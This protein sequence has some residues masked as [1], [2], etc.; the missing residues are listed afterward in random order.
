MIRGLIQRPLCALLRL[1]FRRL[2]VAGRE[3]VPP[4]GPLIFILNHPNA[5]IDPL[6]LLCCTGRPVSFLAKQPLFGMPLI[7]PVV[8]AMESIPVYRRMD[9][10][11]T[12][13]N[14]ATFAAAR[15]LLSRGGSLALFPEGT[16]HSDPRLKPFRTGA[17]RIALGA[18]VA[19]LRIVPAG[20]FYTEKSRFRSQALLCFGGPV[21]V[22]D[23]AA[24]I[25]SEPL[26]EAVRDLTARLEQALGNL[27]LQADEHAALHLAEAAERIFL[28]A[29]DSSRELA[30]RLEIRRRL[31]DGYSR[32]KRS[33][34]DRLTQIVEKVEQYQADLDAAALTPEL[35]PTAGYQTGA[36]LRF[37]VR[38][39]AVL[40]V[41][42]PL[43]LAGVV[44]HFPT[45]LA[46]DLIGRRY[47]RT[48]LD[49]VSTVK[50]IGG[51]VL[52]PLT[53]IALTWVAAARWGGLPALVMLLGLPLSAF[54]ALLFTER[55]RWLLGGARGLAL[56]LTGR[57][58][59]LRLMAERT[60]IRNELLQLAEELGRPPGGGRP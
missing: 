1:F 32:L 45:W 38:A 35:L 59:F 25:D 19:G 26:S 27:T 39:L 60:A 17:A 37:T 29:S 56:S 6:I 49:M 21:E 50:L 40:L 15:E 24:G 51:V 8:R 9:Q 34:P 57:R 47:R 28:S 23:V 43:S 30:N 55:L 3:H 52:Y 41:L 31:L 20:L 46:I 12:A 14:A 33:A 48:N 2:E 10:A 53:W 5:L 18:R 13:K 16:S 4:S 54:A 42:L 44:L 36:V 22:P 58:R 11:D 7:G